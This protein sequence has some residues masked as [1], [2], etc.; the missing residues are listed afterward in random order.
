MNCIAVSGNFRETYN[1]IACIRGNPL[2]EKHVVYTIGKQN[3]MAVAFLSFCE[4]MVVSGWLHDEIID[5]DNAAIH[6]GGDLVELEHFFWET[7]VGG[8]QPLHILVIYLPKRSP[9]IELIF[10]IFSRQVISYR[11][12]HARCW[13]R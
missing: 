4:M 7:V 3:G 6:T 1:L 5:M 8:G 9:Y 2:K 11:L 12:H 13:S 10:H